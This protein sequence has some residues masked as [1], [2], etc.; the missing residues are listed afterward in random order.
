MTYRDDEIAAQ[1][2]ARALKDEIRILRRHTLAGVARD[3][4][5]DIAREQRRSR[6]AA[7]ATARRG[8]PAGWL[9]PRSLTEIVVA[10]AIGATVLTL[11][12]GVVYVVLSVASLL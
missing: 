12:L 3:L 2:R 10:G 6:R 9:L 7:A 11:I 8:K 1:A 4:R 5:A